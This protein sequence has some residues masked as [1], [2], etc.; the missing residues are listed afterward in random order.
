MLTFA[1]IVGGCGKM[2]MKS[3]TYLKIYFLKSTF[4]N[5]FFLMFIS[6]MPVQNALSKYFS[7]CLF[8]ITL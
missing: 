7:K 8:C 4:S 6:K 5:D 1:Y 2:L 3:K